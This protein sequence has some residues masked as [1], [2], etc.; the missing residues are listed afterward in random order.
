MKKH[1]PNKCFRRV[2]Q[3]D[4]YGNLINEYQT[5][6]E[7]ARKYNVDAEKIRLVC[8]GKYFQACNFIWR[9]EKTEFSKED[10]CYI[11]NNSR[12]ICFCQYDKNNNFISKY[13]TKEL[14]DNFKYNKSLIVRASI[15]NETLYNYRWKIA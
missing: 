12:R 15:Y 4:F 11:L 1:L 6:A 13:T 10:L 9:F 7:A 2:Y 3:Y 5:I 8:T 14:R